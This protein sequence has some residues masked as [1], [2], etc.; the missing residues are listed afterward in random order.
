MYLIKKI[1]GLA[2]PGGAHAKLSIFI[3]HRVLP[4]PDPLMPWEPDRRQFDALVGF[5]SNAYNVLALADAAKKLTAGTLPPCAAVITFDDGYA[6]NFTEAREILLKH[7]VSATFFIATSF[8]NGGRMWNDDVIEAIR[9]VNDGVLDLSDFH[10]GRHL[11]N[12]IESRIRCYESILSELKYRPHGTRQKIAR[13][14]A[15]LCG[16]SD[17]S[18]LMMTTG[19]LIALSQ[20]GM[21]IGAHTETHPILNSLSD[22]DAEGEILRGRSSLELILGHKIEVFA[23]PNGAPGRD[24]GDQHVEMVRRAGFIA[25][26]STRVGVGRSNVD[27]QQLPRFTPWDRTVGRFGLRSLA[28]LWRN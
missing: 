28:H 12:N 27:V 13:S 4:E 8:L 1:F 25:A 3:F 20:S 5:I 2:S 19:Q 22:Q 21:E 10:L 18:P 23:Y 15:R 16:L 24:Y 9:V 17:N 14:I 7:G 6:D 11:L 26:V